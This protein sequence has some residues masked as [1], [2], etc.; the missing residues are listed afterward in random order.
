MS[1]T[2]PKL[3]P[4]IY[5]LINGYNEKSYLPVNLKLLEKRSLELI[6]GLVLRIRRL[7]IPVQTMII[8]FVY[9]QCYGGLKVM[10]EYL[11]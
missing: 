8:L 9:I 1:S 7:V 5:R 10:V 4:I 3:R 6:S 11:G 2:Y